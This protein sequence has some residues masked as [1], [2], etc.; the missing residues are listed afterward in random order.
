MSSDEYSVKNGDCHTFW[1]VHQDH[2]PDSRTHTALAWREHLCQG[3][4]PRTFPGD[5]LCGKLGPNGVYLH[6]STREEIWRDSCVQEV[7][8]YLLEP[9]PFCASKWPWLLALD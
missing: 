8:Q 5:S 3:Q 2:Q 7:Y 6:V 1:G 9:C 4:Q